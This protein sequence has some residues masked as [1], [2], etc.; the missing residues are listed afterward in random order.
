ML[1]HELK[2]KLFTPYF[3]IAVFLLLLMFILGSAGK[4]SG[5][6]GSE[7]FLSAIIIKF[8]GR[9][10]D[11]IDSYSI[12]HLLG[13]WDGNEYTPIL[14]PLIVG[15][16]GL[17]V[18]LEEIK[19]GNKRFILDRTNKRRYYATKLIST[20]IAGVFVAL[21]AVFAFWAC[22]FIFF[23]SPSPDDP[24]YPL[25]YIMLTGK[26][27][28]YDIS[29]DISEFSPY[30]LTVLKSLLFYLL[31]VMKSALFM[32]AIAELVK[33]AY[34]TLGI[35]SFASYLHLRISD[36]LSEYSASLLQSGKSENK[37]YDII[38]PVFQKGV[39]RYGYF[40]DRWPQ[41]LLLTLFLMILWSGLFVLLCEK[42][43]DVS[44][45]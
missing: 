17:G 23:K 7:T 32:L 42:Q 44:A 29:H 9:W 18:Y 36:S 4:I 45:G 33:D 28:D 15:L 12:F 40:E 8:H 30:Y 11:C 20:M 31:Y 22:L 27:Y 14:L 19:S 13:F 10:I 5:G 26:Q 34:L 24:N 37:L 39:F 3:F 6:D 38:T 1:K 43:S 16:P 41:A 35:T 25:L 2:K 21:L